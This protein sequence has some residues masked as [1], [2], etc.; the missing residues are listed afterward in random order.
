MEINGL[1]GIKG[2][3]SV[4]IILPGSVGKVKEVWE[5]I[6]NCSQLIEDKVFEKRFKTRAWPILTVEGAR[7]NT[8]DQIIL[9]FHL[10]CGVKLPS[11]SA[12][13]YLQGDGLI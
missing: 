9:N 10:V 7:R 5:T 4:L 8:V 1:E 6:T 3:K 11:I 12:K 2:A 13:S